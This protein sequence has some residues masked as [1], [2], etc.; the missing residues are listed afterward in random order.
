MKGYKVF[1]PDFTCLSFQYEIGKEYKIKDKP[2]LCEKGFHFC[3]FVGDC[4]NYYSFNPN[5]IVCE[6]EALGDI[7]TK[8]DENKC[9]TNH[10][11][12]IRQLNW[13]EVLKL[14][15]HGK[16]NTGYLNTGDRN[17]GYS[18]TGY[19]NTGNLNT[20]DRNTG[21]RN[22]GDRNTGDRNNG[23]SN[24]GD[25]NT[26]YS[27]T[28]YSNTGNWNTGNWN[29]G[30]SNTGDRNTGGFCTGENTIKLFN[31]ESDWT[32]KKFE[33]SKVYSL[34]CQ[35]DTKIW[36]YE[37]SMTDEEKKKYPSFKTSGGYLKDIPYKEAFQNAWLN[38]SEGNRNE[39]KNLPNFD[40]E[41]FELI[42]GVKV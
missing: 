7:D 34:L 42:T 28:G 32:Y 37:S 2:Q 26:G 18:N 5:N 38:W 31:K 17:T 1:N 25:W 12:I 4:F 41:I 14:T 3:E 16:N 13:E 21:D 35:V 11:K 15:N 23:Y 6:I 20:G 30:Y 9:C 24:T 22:T 19:S 10:I 29:T 33:N 40:A 39:F 36:I 8:L 27:N